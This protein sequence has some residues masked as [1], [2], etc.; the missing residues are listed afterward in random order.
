MVFVVRRFIPGCGWRAMIAYRAFRFP[1]RRPDLS[2]L[3]SNRLRIYREAVNLN[4]PSPL[5][6]FAQRRPRASADLQRWRSCSPTGGWK[7]GRFTWPTTKEDAVTL[8]PAQLSMLLEGLEWR[9]PRQ[10]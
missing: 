1:R 3:A 5:A 9:A 7:K 6:I 8:T 2:L 10:T 4:C